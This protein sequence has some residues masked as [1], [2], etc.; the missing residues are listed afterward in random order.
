MA[1]AVLPTML[2]RLESRAR[3]RLAENQRRELERL[4]CPS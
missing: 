1:A 4:D 3:A 2:Y